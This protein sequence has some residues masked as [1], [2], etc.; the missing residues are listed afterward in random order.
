ML[1]WNGRGLFWMTPSTY[2]NGETGI[3]YKLL[4][5][6]VIV[7]KLHDPFMCFCL[8]FPGSHTNDKFH[9]PFALLPNLIPYYFKKLVG[10]AASNLKATSPGVQCLS[11]VAGTRPAVLG[12]MMLN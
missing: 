12:T 5:L 10:L 9:A 3:S 2:S 6:L 1:L 8:W 7:I 11:S 4:F